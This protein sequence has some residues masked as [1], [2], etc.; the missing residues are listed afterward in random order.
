MLI[1]ANPSCIK[2]CLLIRYDE[3]E[4]SPSRA[5][6]D[7]VEKNRDDLIKA[8]NGRGIVRIVDVPMWSDDGRRLGSRR[9]SDAIGPDSIERF[10]DVIVDIS[11]MPRGIYYPILAKLLYLLDEAT[12]HQGSG[13]LHVLVSEQVQ[14]DEQIQEE[15][16][17][18]HAS[19]MHGFS[20]SLV[21]ESTAAVPTIWIPVL[22][23]GKKAQLERIYDHIRPDEICPVLPSPAANP[24]RAD[25]LIAEY[26]RLLF[27]SLRI[28]PRN[29]IYASERNPFEVYRQV[30]GTILRYN[31]VLEA[32]GGCKVVVSALSS[33][34][35]SVGALLAA[36]EALHNNMMVGI[37]HVETQGYHIE[38]QLPKFESE[39][40]TLW[41]AG[42]CYNG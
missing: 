20:S 41:V 6:A 1:E 24:R 42:D 10:E 22:G 35:L 14:I 15:G 2:E 11:A 19:Y 8:M 36:Y 29:F 31:S 23:E 13:N 16:I 38:G 25:N 18:E 30:Y 4:G 28:E 34:L 32:L 40:F 21:R 7:L 12:R 33:K 37:S 39:L 26:R 17:D 27:D 9:A 5:Y 3:G